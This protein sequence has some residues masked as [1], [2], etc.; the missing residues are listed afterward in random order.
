MLLAHNK[1]ILLLIRLE[2]LVRWKCLLEVGRLEVSGKS[3]NEL[4]SEVRNILI[5]NGISPQFQLEISDRI[6]KSLFDGVF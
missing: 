5:R 4:R 1:K 6:T 3:L 2:E